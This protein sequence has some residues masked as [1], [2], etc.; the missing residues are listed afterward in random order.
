MQLKD[1]LN[2]EDIINTLQIKYSYKNVNI[3]LL[4]AVKNYTLANN[5]LKGLEVFFFFEVEN[6]T[7]KCTPEKIVI[8]Q[9]E[10]GGIQEIYA[11][12][13]FEEALREAAAQGLLT[14]KLDKKWEAP[15]FQFYMGDLANSIEYAS[16]FA[17]DD[18]FAV[19][20]KWDGKK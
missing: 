5:Q 6:K 9:K 2:K 16:R 3:N 8:D 20:C 15:A 4:N 14:S 17:A 10:H 7:T 11:I 13:V 1:H 18:P 19:E 12:S